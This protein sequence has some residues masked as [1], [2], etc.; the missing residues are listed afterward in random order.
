MT[1]AKESKL[2]KK[3]LAASFDAF[4]LSQIEEWINSGEPDWSVPKG[5]IKA[6]FQAARRAHES[7]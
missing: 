6:V 2:E 1:T 5:A 7:V 3:Q 4:D